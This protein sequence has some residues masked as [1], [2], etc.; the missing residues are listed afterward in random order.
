MGSSVL[1]YIHVFALGVILMWGPSAS[2]VISAIDAL[3]G[4]TTTA[5]GSTTALAGATTDSLS[6][7]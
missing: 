3:N 5:T 1:L 7:F 6:C 2:T 4:L